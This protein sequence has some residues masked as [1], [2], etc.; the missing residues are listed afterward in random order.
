[1]SCSAFDI[2]KSAM[3]VFMMSIGLLLHA[4]EKKRPIDLK[5]PDNI[6]TVVEFDW[7][8]N[9][10]LVKTMVG[11]TQIGYTIPMT[12]EEYIHR[13]HRAFSLFPQPEP[14]GL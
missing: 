11:D 3:L 1:M 12:R 6:K 10:Y 7:R 9:R 13:A 4:E 14:Q 2:L 8:N 5:T